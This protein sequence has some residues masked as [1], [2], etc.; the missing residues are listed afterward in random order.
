MS[1]GSLSV[2]LG[3]QHYP[4]IFTFSLGSVLRRE[5][6]LDVGHDEHEADGSK[7]G[8]FVEFLAVRT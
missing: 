5:G 1:V 8:S 4:E 3:E 2:P 6:S 7:E